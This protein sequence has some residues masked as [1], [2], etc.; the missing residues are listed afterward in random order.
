MYSCKVV[1]GIC[2]NGGAAFPIIASLNC[3]LATMLMF[4]CTPLGYAFGGQEFTKNLRY[5][6][7]GIYVRLPKGRC[8]WKKFKKKKLLCG[9]KFLEEVLCGWETGSESIVR[10]KKR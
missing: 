10:G 7:P 2:Y 1:R 6:R 5:G 4:S 9:K 3:N 8:Y